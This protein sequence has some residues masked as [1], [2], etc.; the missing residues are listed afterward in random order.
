[1]SIKVEAAI[2]TVVYMVAGLLIAL[3]MKYLLEY[4]DPSAKDVVQV[5][6][7]ICIAVWAYIIYS[8]QVSQL[9]YR[10]K[11]SEIANKE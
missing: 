4:L 2:K 5:V 11:L 10:S 8:F 1:M 7:V 9:E 6:M 3:G